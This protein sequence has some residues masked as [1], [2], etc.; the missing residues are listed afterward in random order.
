MNSKIDNKTL[1]NLTK[2]AEYYVGCDRDNGMHIS[3]EFY[4]SQK[5][6]LLFRVI[7]E[8]WQVNLQ[9]IEWKKEISNFKPYEGI[10]KKHEIICHPDW[11][12][13]YEELAVKERD[14]KMNLQKITETPIYEFKA[15]AGQTLS[16]TEYFECNCCKQVYYRNQWHLKETKLCTLDSGYQPEITIS[17]KEIITNAKKHFGCNRIS[18]HNLKRF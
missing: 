7:Y 11:A 12:I 3:R 17:K 16:K 1:E 10:M 13:Y 14:C 2:I 15:Y 8:T 5:G 9:G 4:E 18:K 6:V